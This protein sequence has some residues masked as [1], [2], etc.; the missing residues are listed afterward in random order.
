VLGLGVTSVGTGMLLGSVRENPDNIP[1]KVSLPVGDLDRS[2]TWFLGLSRIYITNNISIG[3]A[4][5]ARLTYG[6]E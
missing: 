6:R 1:S 5:F 4:V 2:N 3:S